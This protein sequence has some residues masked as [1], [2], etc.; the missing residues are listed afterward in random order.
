E[1]GRGPN[2]DP[3]LYY[4]SIFGKPE[5]HGTWAWRAEGHHLSLNFTIS[6]EDVVVAPSFMG[7]NPGEVREGPRKGLRVLRV[8]E[9]LARQ[10][11]TSLDD[12][13][14]KLAFYAEKA[15]SDV[16]TGADRKAG[17]LE[18]KGIPFS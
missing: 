3:E 15:P 13:Q 5:S 7:A 9:D 10:L 8:E 14:K 18:P 2:R 12:A 16:I 6:G 17:V 11:A 4:F 1:Q